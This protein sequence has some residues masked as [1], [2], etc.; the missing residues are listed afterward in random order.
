MSLKNTES[1]Q[2]VRKELSV[3]VLFHQT[4]RGYPISCGKFPLM[5]VENEVGAEDVKNKT[6]DPCTYL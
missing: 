5:A 3:H 6:K 4:S 2:P 1:P